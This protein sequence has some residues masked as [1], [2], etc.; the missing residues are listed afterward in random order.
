MSPAAEELDEA[1]STDS[2]AKPPKKN[3]ADRIRSR[4]DV[5]AV[6]MADYFA[7]RKQ[8]AAPIASVDRHNAKC[9]V[10][11]QWIFGNRY[12]SFLK[13]DYD[14]CQQ[15]YDKTDDKV[16]FELILKAKKA[17]K[18]IKKAKVVET[19]TIQ[20]D[21]EKTIIVISKTF[22]GPLRQHNVPVKLVEK[23]AKKHFC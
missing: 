6:E 8:D 2:P 11:M 1:R 10:C 18:T 13:N 21:A 23:N 3:R 4:E 9:D 12:K 5:R 7:S 20:K 22:Y 16:S 19:A 17:A 14:L 15:C